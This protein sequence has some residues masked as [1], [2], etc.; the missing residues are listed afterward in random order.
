MV[1]GGEGG[2]ETCNLTFFQKEN[3]HEMGL[4]EVYGADFWWKIH[5]ATSPIDLAGFRGDPGRPKNPESLV[6]EG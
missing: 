6:F 1:T 2:S 4:D 5:S 3:G